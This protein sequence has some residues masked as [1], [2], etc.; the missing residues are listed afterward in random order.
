MRRSILKK[1]SARSKRIKQ[2]SV[3]AILVSI[4]LFSV[5]GYAFGNFHEEEEKKI[6]YNGREFVYVDG[7]WIFE[8]GDFKFTLMNAPNET[9]Q[10]GSSI[11]TLNYYSNKPLYFSSVSPETELYLYRNFYPTTNKI[12]QR[13]QKACLEGE[14]C[15]GDLPTKTCDENFMIIREAEE[16]NIYQQNSCVFIEGPVEE[17][18]GVLDSF[19][20]KV[21][22]IDK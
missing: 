11:K 14:T 21:T 8:Q 5:L 2:I 15:E 19:I 20:L 12:V 3:S 16:K 9:E 13:I 7:F 10:I 4:L 1:E 18:V 22:G 17:L 6:N